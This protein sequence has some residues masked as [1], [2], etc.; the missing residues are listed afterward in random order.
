MTGPGA[1]GSASARAG[2]GRPIAL[3]LLAAILTGIAACGGMATNDE[4]EVLVPEASGTE[5]RRISGTIEF[6]DLEGGLWVIRADGAT[7]DPTNLPESYREAGMAIEAEVV[8]REDV[9][10][11][12]MV[13]SIVQIVRLRPEKPDF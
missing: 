12:G 2:T 7:Y 10:S 8:L 4:W 9:A 11:I 6:V 13:G 5:T 3:V 1:K